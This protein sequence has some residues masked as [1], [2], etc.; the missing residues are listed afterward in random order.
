VSIEANLQNEARQKAMADVRALIGEAGEIAAEW[1]GFM[2]GE[3]NVWLHDVV[4]ELS[5][6]RSTGSK[7]N[8]KISPQLRRAVLERDKYRCQN[9]GGWEDLGV[10]HKMPRSK[11]GEDTLDNL[12]A[13]CNPCNSAKGDRL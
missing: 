11:G 6:R 5:P 3:V 7:K 12:Q 8:H 1:D 9:C 13:M 4:D 10:D 2:C